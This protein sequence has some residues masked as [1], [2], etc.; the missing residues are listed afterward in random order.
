MKIINGK[1]WIT[2]DE[3]AEKIA[4]GK[5]RP[6]YLLDLCKQFDYPV[7]EDPRKRKPALIKRE[8]AE[9]IKAKFIR[10]SKEK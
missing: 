4:Q 3:A 1:E 10:A 7:K 2:V 9:F 6:E 5:I 8:T